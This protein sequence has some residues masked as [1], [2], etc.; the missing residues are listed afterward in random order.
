MRHMS[1]ILALALVATPLPAL[2]QQGAGESAAAGEEVARR[3]C[4]AC[5]VVAEG[6]LIAQSDAPSF[7]EIAEGSDGDFGWLPAFL[8]DP[9]PAMPRLSLS[10]QQIRDLGAYLS[11][12]R[13]A[14]AEQPAEAEEAAAAQGPATEAPLVE[15]PPAQ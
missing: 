4:A 14:E 1:R 9:H 11:S 3:W 7:M 2:A 5:H 12:L 13:P 10:R 6:Q 15:E 8:A